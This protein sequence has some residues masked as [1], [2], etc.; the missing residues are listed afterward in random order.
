MNEERQ[1]TIFHFRSIV[2]CTERRREEER[3]E[4]NTTYTHGII[5]LSW[6]FFRLSNCPKKKRKKKTFIYP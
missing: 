3:R 1:L 4:T 5:P 6:N 2:Y